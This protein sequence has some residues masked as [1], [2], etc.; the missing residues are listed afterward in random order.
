MNGT[1][2]VKRDLKV[3]TLKPLQN[4]L[5]CTIMHAWKLQ[6]KGESFIGPIMIAQ[7]AFKKGGGF[8]GQFSNR[9][10]YHY[11]EEVIPCFLCL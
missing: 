2:R 9:Y 1:S 6:R 7:V 10:F 4:L 3:S 5:D 8:Q 11:L